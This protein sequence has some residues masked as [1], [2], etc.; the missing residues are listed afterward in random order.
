MK[1]FSADEKNHRKI[2]TFFFNKKAG[3]R[4]AILYKNYSGAGVSLY[5]LSENFCKKAFLKNTSGSCL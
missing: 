5:E 4:S 1:H 2:N 3:C